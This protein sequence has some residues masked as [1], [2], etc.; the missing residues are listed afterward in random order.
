MKTLKHAFAL[1]VVIMAVSSC[2]VLSLHPIG[3]PDELIMDESL[4]GDW[5][6]DNSQDMLDDMRGA[7]ENFTNP[8]SAFLKLSQ[9]PR[10]SFR[11]IDHR[12]EILKECP[13]LLDDDIKMGTYT[14]EMHLT[15]IDGEYW[16]SF[17]P[18]DD[19]RSMRSGNIAMHTFGIKGH[20]MAK[21]KIS[22]DEI[23]I[24]FLNYNWFK[25]MLEKNRMRIDHQLVGGGSSPQ[26]VLTANT[27]Q[28]RAMMKRITN[29]PKAFEEEALIIHR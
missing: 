7:T 18:G 13:E 17:S 12:Y 20:G 28:L 24:N 6:E 23:E 29:E 26:I 5:Y 2:D 15:K 8:D 4:F 1:L 11:Q 27:A 9:K 16:A 3:T 14:Y 22:N 21:L 19:N 10:Y 25:D